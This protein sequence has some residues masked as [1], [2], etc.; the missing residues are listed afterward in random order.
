MQLLHFIYTYGNLPREFTGIGHQKNKSI[1]H[2]GSFELSIQDNFVRH[3]D[4]GFW[5]LDRTKRE[6]PEGKGRKTSS[7]IS[8]FLL[9]TSNFRLPAF[10]HSPTFTPS[11]RFRPFSS[12]F[13]SAVEK[14]SM[15]W[16]T[17]CQTQLINPYCGSCSIRKT[18]ATLSQ[19]LIHAPD[20]FP[21]L[22]CSSI[23]FISFFFFFSISRNTTHFFF[24][25]DIA[26]VTI[27]RIFIV[28]PW[29]FNFIVIC[30]ILIV[31]GP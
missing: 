15:H 9:D 31:K 1:S 8:N 21:L 23:S 12:P 26:I 2:W 19:N 16:P 18:H 24:L 10:P 3:W 22:F 25:R 6:Q 7:V 27:F 5:G 20:P 17:L 13:H 14:P 4:C 11:L 30:S 29:N 28:L